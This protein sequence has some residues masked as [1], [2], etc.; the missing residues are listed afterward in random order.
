MPSSVTPIRNVLISIIIKEVKEYS[1]TYKTTALKALDEGVLHKWFYYVNGQLSA[2]NEPL[3][4]SKR[5]FFDMICNFILSDKNI[6]PTKYLKLIHKYYNY[7]LEFL[8]LDEEYYKNLCDS[9][10]RN[11]FELKILNLVCRKL[12]VY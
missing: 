12:Y 5:D 11:G 4:L 2:R 9:C 3:T 6:I 1:A 7:V 8:P 10:I